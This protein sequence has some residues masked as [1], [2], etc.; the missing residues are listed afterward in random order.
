[1]DVL[2][3]CGML[4]KKIHDTLEKNANNELR[5]NGMT[6]AQMQMLVTLNNAE[7]GTCF[8]KELETELQIA[9]STTVGIVKRLE[10][11]GLVEGY[12][13][14]N[15][16][17]MKLVKI[18][19]AGKTVCHET[20]DDMDATEQRLLQGLTKLEREQLRVLLQ[21]VHKGFK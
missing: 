16:K 6:L 15:D 8:L 1:M 12:T 21:K 18:T 4:I 10:L 3:P 20:K 7:N 2:E 9:Q 17:R 13:D 11:K 14:P 19:L 5:A